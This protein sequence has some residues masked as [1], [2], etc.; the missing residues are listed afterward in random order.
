MQLADDIVDN[1]TLSK[2]FGVFPIVN[3]GVFTINRSKAKMLL[4]RKLS[5]ERKPSAYKRKVNIRYYSVPDKRGVSVQ[6][7]EKADFLTRR[8]EWWTEKDLVRTTPINPSKFFFDSLTLKVI[9]NTDITRM[10]LFFHFIILT[11][12]WESFIMCYNLLYA[13]QKW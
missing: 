1:P 3:H 12:V 6:K 10:F 9:W 13:N 8:N 4:A 5:L 11:N 7:P 2:W